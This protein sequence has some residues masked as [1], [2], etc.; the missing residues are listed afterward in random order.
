MV[1][2]LRHAAAYGQVFQERL[3]IDG[4]TWYFYRGNCSRWLRGASGARRFDVQD[5]PAQRATVIMTETAYQIWNDFCA[6]HRIAAESVPLFASNESGFVE[7]K[8]IG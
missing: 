2:T 7:L 5:S 3:T 6:A 8:E 1:I 4:Q